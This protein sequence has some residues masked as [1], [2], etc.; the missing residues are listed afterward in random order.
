MSCRRTVKY[1]VVI[2]DGNNK[3]INVT[4]TERVQ[5]HQERT[6][7]HNGNFIQIK[8]NIESKKIHEKSR[9]R[10]PH[11]LFKKSILLRYFCVSVVDFTL[12][13]L[14]QYLLSQILNLLA[15]CNFFLLQSFLRQFS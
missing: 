10:K 2:I 3:H 6:K 15:E 13:L 4:I 5:E 9:W 14:Y 7:K 11:I 8:D 12:I 1:L